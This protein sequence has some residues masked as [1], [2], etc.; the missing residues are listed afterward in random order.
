MNNTEKLHNQCCYVIAQ[1][2]VGMQLRLLFESQFEFR[3]Q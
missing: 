2:Y 1:I 3:L